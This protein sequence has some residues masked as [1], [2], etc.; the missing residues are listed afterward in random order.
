LECK[1]KILI[2]TGN[3]GK[4]KEFKAKL[5]G[6]GITVVS[7]RELGELPAPCETGE[8]FL[9]NAYIKAVH[10]ASFF[11]GLVMAEDSGLEVE[12]LGGAPGVRSARFAGEGAT[13]EENVQKLIEELR[14]AGVDSSPARYVSC[15]VVAGYG[16]AGLWSVGEVR[17]TVITERRGTGG[18]G[19]DPVF[20]PEG[21]TLTMAQLSVQEKN[22]ISH[23]ALALDRILPL[24]RKT[25]LYNHSADF[26]GQ[27]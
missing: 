11:Q 4:L 3:P 1:V 26:G 23:R 14:K 8:T 25:A 17:G 27:K 2:A 6:T 5:D 18:F 24:L 15:I 7:A 9:E 12:V 19:Y 22:R 20:V 16:G 10:Y 21:Y 13:D